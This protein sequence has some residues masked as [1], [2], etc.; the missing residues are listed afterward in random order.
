MLDDEVIT[1]VV[2]RRLRI[3]GTLRVFWF[4][5]EAEEANVRFDFRAEHREQDFRVHVRFRFHFDDD[6][7]L[8]RIGRAVFVAKDVSTLR[9][10]NR[11]WVFLQ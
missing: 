5:V 2:R 6:R 8:R 9:V 10:N 7:I 3:I 4:H 1:P 11:I